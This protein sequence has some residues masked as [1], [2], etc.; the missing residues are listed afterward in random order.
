MDEQ[1]FID[2]IS[3]IK[4]EK[5]WPRLILTRN[6]AKVVRFALALA[7]KKFLN[8]RIDSTQKDID[9]LRLQIRVNVSGVRFVPGCAPM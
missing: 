2:N 1:V 8:W 3:E 6:A 7:P 4:E 9:L 5:R